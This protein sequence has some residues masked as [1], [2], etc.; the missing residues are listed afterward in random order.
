VPYLRKARLPQG[1]ISLEDDVI[2]RQTCASM[3]AC[4]AHFGRLFARLVEL[5]IQVE[6]PSL[7]SI[8]TNGQCAP[9][10]RPSHS[11]M[12]CGRSQVCCC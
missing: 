2:G 1:S 5:P 9:D 12:R 6:R 10:L 4:S 3:V 7:V 8:L 11:D